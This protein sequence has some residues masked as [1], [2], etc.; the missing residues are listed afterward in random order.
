MPAPAKASRRIAATGLIVLG[1]LL[2][3]GLRWWVAAAAAML[4]VA[5]LTGVVVR[6]LRL[7]RLLYARQCPFCGYDL[8]AS[9]DRCP[10]CGKIYI[11]FSI[12]PECPTPEPS[13]VP[14]AI[15]FEPSGNQAHGWTTRAAAPSDNPPLGCSAR[16]AAQGVRG[17][18]F[19]VS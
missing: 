18:A 1:A 13:P 9:R 4:P 14:S 15:D 6:Q 8:R 17:G 19:T 5:F 12:P 3:F 7:N 16:A 11:E 2:P 10:E